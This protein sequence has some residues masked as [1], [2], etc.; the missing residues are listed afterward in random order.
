MNDSSWCERSSP[1]APGMSLM[2]ASDT[3]AAAMAPLV[4]T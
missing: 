1:R 4:R 2:M 3:T